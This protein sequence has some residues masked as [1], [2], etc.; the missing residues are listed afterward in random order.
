[1][2]NV[3]LSGVFVWFDTHNEGI[4]ASVRFDYVWLPNVALNL[5]VV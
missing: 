2:S 4:D 3:V 1:M 5:T